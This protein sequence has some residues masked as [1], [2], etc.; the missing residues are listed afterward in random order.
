M[1]SKAKAAARID[2][3]CELLTKYNE[4]YYLRDKPLVSDAEWDTLMRELI[5]LEEKY[6]ELRRPDSPTQRVGAAPQEKFP[7]FVH[8]VP[9]LSLAN[10]MDREELLAFN[11][12]V[13][14]LL[15]AN[16]KGFEYHCELKFDGLSI[17]LTYEAGV[18]T[19]AAT[20]GDGFEGEEVTPNVRTIRNVPLRLK[21]KHP[22]RLVEVRGEIVLPIPAFQALNQ[23]R[24][25]E[26]E[27]VF[28]NPRNAA[29]GSVRQ[30]D[31]TLTAKRDLRLF[32]YALGGV[33]GKL[34]LKTQAGVQDLLIEWGFS[35]PPL[36][37]CC[38]D[39][40]GVL[41]FYEHVEKAREQLEFDIDGVVVKLN[42]LG[43]QE[44]LGFVARSPRAM[45]AAKFPPR[46]EETVLEEI[47]IQVGRT[48]VLSPVAKLRPVVVHGVK[49]SRASLHNQE[50][51]ERKDVRIG[52]HVIV[53]RA[54]DV[55]PEIVRSIPEKR[56]GKE[57]KFK[58]PKHC[59]SCGEETV[60]P[61]G[62][63]AIRCVNLQCPAQIK[64]SLEHFVSKYGM[65]IVGLGPRI[66]E[67]F[68]AA[69]LVTRFSDIYKIRREDILKLEGFKDKS[70]DKLLA[71]IAAS[72]NRDLG[73]LIYA[74][75]IRH[76]GEQLAKSLAKRFCSLDGLMKASLEE[77]TETEDVGPIVAASVYDYF[78]RETNI[79][80][81]KELAKLGIQPRLESAK[82]Q[83]ANLAGMT[84][85]ITGTLPKFERKDMEKLIEAH[86]G[87][88]SSSVS[89]KTSY[90]IVGENAG[91]KLDK[92]RDL[93]VPILTE[94]EALALIENPR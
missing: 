78:R 70:A 89:K 15:P 74:L 36:R 87:K 11:E 26:G 66:L 67:A 29:A 20:R 69:K 46:Q 92:A 42:D 18:L 51:I 86:G 63:V 82:P 52:D 30:L 23:Q 91:S 53:Q 3:L 83:S 28:A 73:A 12:R 5:A 64:E 62:E 16:M 22:P 61:E 54:G 57:K 14:K 37:E 90:I 39:I 25:E 13:R 10:A 59:P 48:G 31:S 55:I 45:I 41:K 32:A 94:A 88:T 1:N 24:Q 49:V 85:V 79:Q 81:V 21:T 71:A 76:V 4:A 9:M 35:E 2:E 84:F 6:P 60:K 65:D 40:A 93:G 50:E 7:K 34:P 75:G 68:I 33:E 38:G 56:T 17:N 27:E 72:K 44:E 43:L 47:L 77:L 80:E 19:H 8:K 58:F